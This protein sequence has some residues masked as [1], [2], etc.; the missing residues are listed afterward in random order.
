MNYQKLLRAAWRELALRETLANVRAD[1][2]PDG[3]HCELSTD[4]HHLAVRNW[5]HVRTLAARHRVPVPAEMDA[6][7]ER[8][9]EF[10]LHVHKPDGVVPSLSDGDARGFLDVDPDP[11]GRFRAR[12]Y[13]S[14]MAANRPDVQPK[15]RKPVLTPSMC[16][17]ISVICHQV[18]IN[19]IPRKTRSP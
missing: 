16:Q 5:L 19:R 6:L 4:Y 18:A 14:H 12:Q 8:A 7:L 2:L 13:L 3:V 1:L 11:P 17:F 9:L 15:M 10:C